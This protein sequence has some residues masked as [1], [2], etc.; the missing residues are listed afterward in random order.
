MNLYLL[1]RKEVDYDE[2]DAHLI[3]ASSE[4]RAREIASRH[5]RHEPSYEWLDPV[6]STCECVEVDGIE[7]VVL[8][9]FLAG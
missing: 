9:S 8:S 1:R 4:N 5:S 6:A 2:F 7:G 3:R